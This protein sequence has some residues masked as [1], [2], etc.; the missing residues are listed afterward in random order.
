MMKSIT[1]DDLAHN[2]APVW[3]L[4]HKTTREWHN[5]LMDKNDGKDLVELR[6]REMVNEFYLI[7]RDT[8]RVLEPLIKL[9]ER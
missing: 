2:P 4:F 1:K 6:D 5:E 9:L 3:S 7:K 8:W